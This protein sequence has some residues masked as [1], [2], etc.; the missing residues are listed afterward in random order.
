MTQI[1]ALCSRTTIISTIIDLKTSVCHALVAAGT[2]LEGALC[3]TRDCVFVHLFPLQTSF[4]ITS[5]F[6]SL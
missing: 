2:G 5:S 3:D 4:K 6:F 1:L